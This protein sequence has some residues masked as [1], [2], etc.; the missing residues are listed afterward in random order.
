MLDAG[1]EFGRAGDVTGATLTVTD[2]R[3]E[4]SGT[5]QTPAGS[6]ATGYFVVVF[7]VNREFWKPQ[8]RR[9][10]FARPADDGTFG[11]RD[12]PAGEYLLAALADLDPPA[13]DDPAFLDQLLSAS[14][15]VLINDGQPHTQNLRIGG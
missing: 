15:K 6:P 14:V 8:S 4:L 3:S 7:P 12:L 9:V 13:L 10:K 5:L 2:R 1:L 11:F